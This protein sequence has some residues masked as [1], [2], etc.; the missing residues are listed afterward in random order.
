MSEPKE[1]ILELNQDL[2]EWRRKPDD[3]GLGE[4]RA[5]LEHL[6]QMG[7]GLRKMANDLLWQVRCL[8]QDLEL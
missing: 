6:R 8:E 5:R 3:A 1:P 2:G 7:I 4:I